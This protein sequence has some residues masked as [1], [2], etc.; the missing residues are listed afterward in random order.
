MTREFNSADELAAALIELIGKKIVLGLPVGIGKAIRVADA[1]YAR[2]EADTSISLTIFTGLT[3]L[4]PRGRSKLESAFLQPLVERLYGGC[5]RPLYAEAV[6]AGNLPSN[7]TV[8]EFYLRPGGYLRNDQAQQNYTSINYSQVAAELLR[9]GV[10]VI[11]QLVAESA[12]DSNRY[13][14]ASNPEITLDLLPEFDRLRS[15]GAAIALVGERNVN[16]PYMPG[17]A[18]LDA[19]RFDFILASNDT[20]YPL[21]GLPNRRVTSGDYAIAMHVASLVP[22]GGTLQVGIGSMSDAVAHC[23]RLRQD[24]PDVFKAVLGMLP[25]GTGSPRRAALPVETAPFDQGLYA[26][27]ELLSDALFSLLQHGIVRRA[28]DPSD[29]TLVHAGFFVGSNAFYAS[30]RELPPELRRRI[31]MTCISFVNTLFG[32]EQRKRE[33]RRQARFVN[34]TMMATLLG[35]AVSDTLD[36]GRVVSGVGGQFD[37]VSMASKLQDAHSILMLKARREHDGKARSN[38]RWN[39]AHATVPRHHR[40]IYVS[41][42]GIAATRGL[43]DRQ[44][45][46]AMLCIADSSVQAELATQAQK[47]RKLPAG[48]RLPK[49]ATGNSPDALQ[50]VFGRDEL[51]QYFPDYPLGTDLTPVEQKLAVALEWLDENTNRPWPRLRTMAAAVAGSNRHQAAMARMGLDDASGIGKRILRRMLAYA[52]TETQS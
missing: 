44:V 43:P 36:D 23:L 1:L 22:D 10:N 31:N 26:C 46:E 6:A 34:E 52:L 33:Q 18:E 35:A 29:D 45:I 42:Y 11:A 15:S 48:F 51:R 24:S 49:D 27:T 40:D 8:R 12:A 28:A 30:L 20:D 16:L 25:G 50:A 39:Y 3:L 2:A 9:L 13:S 21:F 47:A 4:P 17:D 7:I 37:F 19:S 41:E 38:I 32:D 14:L 5:P